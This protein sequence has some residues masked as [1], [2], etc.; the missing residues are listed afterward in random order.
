MVSIGLQEVEEKI[1]QACKKVGRSRDEITLVAVTKTQP[2]SVILEGYQ[3]GIRDFGENRVQELVEKVPHLPDDINW[4]MIGHLQRNKVKQ[5]VGKVK[6]IHSVDSLRLAE[7]IENEY[8]KKGLVAD[9]LLE[10]NVSEEESKFGLKI[11]ETMPLIRKIHSYNHIKVKGLMAM[12]PFTDNSETNRK[13]FIALKK[14]SVDI[15]REKLDNVTMRVLSMGMTNDYQVAVEEGATILRVGT[16]IF[17]A[18]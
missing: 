9:I 10:V 2:L 15:T 3:E 12:A 4:H 17:G 18:R 7:T 11:N 14:L 8:S 1:V 16:G 6:L 13:F 5:L